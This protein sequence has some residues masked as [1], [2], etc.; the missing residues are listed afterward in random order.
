MTSSVGFSL[1]DI[2]KLSLKQEDGKELKV[3]DLAVKLRRLQQAR[4][5]LEEE[6]LEVQTLKG[7]LEQ[8]EETLCSEAFQIDVILKEKKESHRIL[9]FKCEE[10]DQDSQRLQEQNKQKEELVEQYRY[11]IQEAT[12]KHR[13]TRM[14]F[15]NQLQQLMVQHKSLS[16]MFR[17][18][19][20][21]SWLNNRRS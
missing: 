2:L 11:Q 16:S 9:Q 7:L 12:L 6:L 20:W 4:R 17:N 10:L 5:T 14:K 18:S 8:E 3:E 15:E 21:S 13:K 1:D 19:G